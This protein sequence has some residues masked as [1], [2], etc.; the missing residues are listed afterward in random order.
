MVL[1]KVKNHAMVH[2]GLV[3]STGRSDYIYAGTQVLLNTLFFALHLP[4]SSVSPPPP[5]RPS[6]SFFPSSPKVQSRYKWLFAVQLPKHVWIWLHLSPTACKTKKKTG[7]FF[8]HKLLLST[9]KAPEWRCQSAITN[10]CAGGGHAASLS[11]G[12]KEL[13]RVIV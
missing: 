6:L 13:R 7:P 1:A 10:V 9:Q 8:T 12:S 11:V 2:R 4:R 3:L 5:L